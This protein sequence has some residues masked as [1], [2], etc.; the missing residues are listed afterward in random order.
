MQSVSLYNTGYF[1]QDRR[2]MHEKTPIRT[3]EYYEIELIRTQ[4]AITYVDDHTYPHRRGNVLIARPGQRRST[5]GCFEAYFA[6]FSCNDNAF[7]KQYLDILP[8]V[9]YLSADAE[10]ARL[11]EDLITA[12]A[13]PSPA[14]H[15]VAHARLLEIIAY[16]NQVSHIYKG[17]G[18]TAQR[19]QI[20]AAVNYIQTHYAEPLTLQRMAEP[21]ALSPTYFHTVFKNV[22]GTT[23]ADFLLQTR[24][25]A[26]KRLLLTTDLSLYAIAQACGYENQSY[27]SKVFRERIGCPPLQFRKNGAVA[28]D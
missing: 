4:E 12:A 13:E 28:F 17:G 1:V 27:F 25:T 20:E 22:I 18:Y 21:A 5:Y 8:Q 6:R 24:M 11:Y 16:L 19:P 3:T 2:F 15:L 10:L 14:C 7:R 26:A 23:P 9:L